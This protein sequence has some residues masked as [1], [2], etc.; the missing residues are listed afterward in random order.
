MPI[1][2]EGGELMKTVEEVRVGCLELRVWLQAAKEHGAVAAKK[3]GDI[4]TQ[5]D[6][7]K[8]IESEVAAEFGTSLSDEQALR[9]ERLD[10]ARSQK[11]HERESGADERTRALEQ[12]RDALQKRAED[13]EIALAQARALICAHAAESPTSGGAV[14]RPTVVPCRLR[15]VRRPPVPR[16]PPT[17]PCQRTATGCGPCSQ[18]SLHRPAPHPCPPPPQAHTELTLL[19]GGAGNVDAAVPRRASAVAK[20]PTMREMRSESRDTMLEVEA[21]EAEGAR[22]QRLRRS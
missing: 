15:R 19:S 4:S 22:P 11:Q 12:E 5:I 16:R 20:P 13:A 14:G 2:G 1:E 3:L 18:P 10:R 6:E 17:P 21:L 7:L 9:S 8:E